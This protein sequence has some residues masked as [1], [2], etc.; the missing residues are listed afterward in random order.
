MIA[1]ETAHL[2]IRKRY[3]TLTSMGMPTWKV[4]GYCEYIARDSTIPLDEGIR[5]W[6]ENPTDDTGYRYIKYHLMIRHLLEKEGVTVDDVFN[7]SFDER[8]VSERTFAA[9]R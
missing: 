3:G 8:E 9:I 7:G 5:R 1:H 6:R 4:E 2:L